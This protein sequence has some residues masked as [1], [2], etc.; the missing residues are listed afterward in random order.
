VGVVKLVGKKHIMYNKQIS[1]KFVSS[2]IEN[3]IGLSDRQITY[4]KNLW[5]SGCIEKC[6]MTRSVIWSYL[7]RVRKIENSGTSK[8][9]EV[10][11]SSDWA[12]L[13]DD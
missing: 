1:Y 7:N 3:P 13:W 12:L 4:L 10:A 9:Q 11:K 5:D 6:R 2:L 8:P